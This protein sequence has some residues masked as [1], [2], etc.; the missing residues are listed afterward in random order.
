M[1]I[2]I[3]FYWYFNYGGS[4]VEAGNLPIYTV[5]LTINHAQAET[6]YFSLYEVVQF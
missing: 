3:C 6:F 2:S 4:A 5:D 1:D